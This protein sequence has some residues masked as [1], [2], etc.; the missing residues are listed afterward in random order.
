MRLSPY[1]SDVHYIMCRQNYQSKLSI[2]ANMLADGR[3]VR[4]PCAIFVATKHDVELLCS[5]IDQHLN[6]AKCAGLYGKMD[7]VAREMALN[8]FINL[9]AD[10]LVVTDVAARGIDI[11][12]LDCVVNFNFPATGKLFIHRIGRVARRPSVHGSTAICLVA[13]DEIPRLLDVHLLLGFEIEDDDRFSLEPGYSNAQYDEIIGRILKDQLSEEI[14]RA[15]NG[16]C[17]Y[18]RSLKPPSSQSVKTFKEQKERYQALCATEGSIRLVDKWRNAKKSK[19]LK[20]PIDKGINVKNSDKKASFKDLDYFIP[21]RQSDCDREEFLSLSKNNLNDAVDDTVCD[22]GAMEIQ[23]NRKPKL[24]WDRKRKKYVSVNIEERQSVAKFKRGRY[25][26]W[27]EKSKHI[28]RIGTTSDQ[29]AMDQGF[30]SHGKVR[31]RKNRELKSVQQV[32]KRRR[33]TGVKQK[34]EKSRRSLRSKRKGVK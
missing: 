10:C 12:A 24:R 30:K 25:K 29:Q 32:L 28:D 31:H 22:E 17:A 15:S 16:Y 26:S 34:F 4:R 21:Y 27:L 19:G 1:L 33:I 20:N 9:K 7:Q 11:P 23:R 3:Y 8:R 2:L 6:L 14:K 5:M 18:L 13:V